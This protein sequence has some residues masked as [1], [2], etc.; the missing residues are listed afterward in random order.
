VDPVVF[1]LVAAGMSAMFWRHLR[2]HQHREVRALGT[3]FESDAEVVL[4]VA[5]H[6]ARARGA[7]PTSVHILYGL[8]QDEAITSAIRATG[9]DP[10]AIE[11]AVLAASPCWLRCA[12]PWPATRLPSTPL[13]AVAART[14]GRNEGAGLPFES[15]SRGW[16]AHGTPAQ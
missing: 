3:A 8:L 11:G 9:G 14:S 1:A 13:R 15:G 2:V 16:V 10:D 7:L 4:H 6:E 5:T 12:W